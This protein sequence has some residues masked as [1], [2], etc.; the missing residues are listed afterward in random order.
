MQKH[1]STYNSLDEYADCTRQFKSQSVLIA[2]RY[3]IDEETGARPIA[4]LTNAW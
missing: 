3:M 4:N 2:V 1:T